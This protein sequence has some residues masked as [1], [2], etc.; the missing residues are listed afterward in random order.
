M[1]TDDWLID[2]LIELHSTDDQFEGLPVI[3]KYFGA[4]EILDR[5]YESENL[6]FTP[7]RRVIALFSK[8]FELLICGCFA[9]LE[10]SSGMMIFFG[11]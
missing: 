10:L 6:N 5:N 3:Q 2:W 1:G 11:K 4:P 8:F 9:K 7:L